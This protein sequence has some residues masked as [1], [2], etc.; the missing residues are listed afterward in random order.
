ML[1]IFF[2]VHPIIVKNHS[3]LLKCY[4]F[5]RSHNIFMNMM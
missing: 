5:V 3:G 2:L 4:F 1:S